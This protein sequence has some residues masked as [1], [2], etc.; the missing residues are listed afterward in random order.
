MKI[1]FIGLGNMGSGMALNLHKAGHEVSGFDL[2][3]AAKKFHAEQGIRVAG[4]AKEAAAGAEVVITML[5]ASQ[6]VEGMFIGSAEQPGLLADMPAGTL[7]IDSSTIAADTAR[8]V[9]KAAAAKGV[10][11][12]DAPVSGGT[13]GAAAGT[14]TF[15]VGGSDAALERARPLLE[16]MGKNI[17]HAG[18][19]GAGQTAK[20]CNNMLLG[21]LMIGTSEALALGMANGLD[22]K[23]LS[24]I[25]R[26]SSGG[27]WT[28][29]V[30]NP[31]PGV[32]EA[33]AATRGYTG[34]FG[35][36]LMLKD[37]G[38]ALENAVTAKASTPLGAMARSIYAAH[39]I[40]GH[41]GEDFS[42]IIKMLQK[43][44]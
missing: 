1:A 41:G 36:D 32:Q 43:Q 9:G 39:S 18:D 15:M 35:T 28:L 8:K 24:E 5:P 20:I 26:R 34:G 12:I 3:E 40:G 33:S 21:I 11:F 2:S 17:F 42:S 4:S 27:N 13:A 16:K 7:I 37:L 25:M 10:D 31:V 29:E 30:Y 6:H 19:V 22:P 44:A 23:V 14:L 38:L